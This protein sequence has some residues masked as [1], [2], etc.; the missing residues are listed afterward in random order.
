MKN[1]IPFEIRIFLLTILSMITF[2]GCD[3][4]DHL[5]ESITDYGNLF[6][7]TYTIN[8]DG[9]CV[10]EGLE[11]A[12]ATVI[13]DEVAKYGWK[14]VGIFE[15]Q[16]DGRLSR[17]DYRTTVYGG[18]YTDYWFEA[19]G[20]LIG[21]QHGDVAGKSYD[22]TEWSY[23]AATGFIMRGPAS[24]STQSRY[25]Q[26]LRFTKTE[27]R[28]RQ[29]Y[30][31]QKLGITSDEH[32]DKPFYAMVVYQRMTDKELAEIKNTY[33]YD[34]NIDFP[35]AVPND[36]KFR[37][38]VQYSNPDESEEETD[39]SVLVT[40]GD[41]TFSLTDHLGTTL[42]PNPA[43]EY[44]DYIVWRTDDRNLPDSYVIHRQKQGQAQTTLTWTTRFFY[45][46]SDLTS[47]FDGYK[48]GRVVYTYTMRHNVY[49][50]KFLCFDWG[51]FAMSKPRQF[52]AT[53]LLDQKRSF[54]VYEPRT[55]NN[56]MN[57]VYAELRYNAGEKGTGNDMALLL[58]EACELTELMTNHY[59][60]GLDAGKQA[61][62]YCALFQ[63]LPDHA[64]IITYWETADTR[65]ALV[66]NRDDAD[67]K[68]DY[69]YVRAEPMQ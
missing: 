32:G 28:Y 69:Y 66:L 60:K 45:T 59:G 42:L 44:F 61:E 20:H 55:Y 14:V 37:V 5:D 12:G 36:C 56:D 30:T 57:K 31:L 41:V 15:V 25:M 38:S 24:Q 23:D 29:M 4:S 63:T 19:D 18:G 43:L 53:C 33:G 21:F 10:L 64:E 7:Y 48:N 65:I 11:P 27:S 54:T 40:F 9:C 49:N 34:A 39:G 68:N 22:K 46:N 52:T 16:D 8:D 35:G 6:D 50:D 13:E 26:V 3:K 1:S 58:E 47:Y 2:T 67:P 62:H 17:T 51:R